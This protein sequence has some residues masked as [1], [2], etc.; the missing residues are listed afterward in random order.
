MVMKTVYMK[1]WC[2]LIVT[3][4]L[5]SGCSNL[6]QVTNDTT[7]PAT[8][9]TEAKD[10]TPVVTKIWDSAPHSAFTSL[11][12]FNNA[13]YC[14]FREATKHVGGTDGK[15]R[16]IKSTDG[17]QWESVALLEKATID[18][19]DPML[20]ITPDNR[21]MVSIGGSVYHP[22]E[23]SK[24]LGMS[25]MVSY[26]DK[27]GA[28][29]SEAEKVTVKAPGD[30][31]WIWRVTWHKGVGYGMSYREGG[32][33]LMKTT[34]G[35]VFES[36]TKLD[37]SG[38]PNESTV[39]FDKNDQMYVMVRREKEDKMGILAK[40]KSPYNNWTYDTMNLRLGGPNFLFYNKEK[41]LIVGT[42]LWDEP[43]GPVTGI[44]LTD[45]N[46]KILKTIKL[47]SGGDCSYPG[48]VL[49]KDTCYVTY[50]SSH[51]E[52]SAIYFTAIPFKQLKP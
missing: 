49:Y 25:P 12:R 32:L 6:Q 2:A 37:I 11:V 21:L 8:V 30:R 16:I 10:D 28:N 9:K 50:Y 38:Y 19:R 1:T 27:H 34:D 51:G 43:G 5:L 29:F 48:L 24:L 42:R 36:V 40:S 41:Q 17:K 26:S 23:R 46:G 15:I 14:C 35:K 44:L 20:S 4:G 52:K 22:E 31:N 33:Y 3:T 7:S 45:L 18:L 47:P 39:R 13:F